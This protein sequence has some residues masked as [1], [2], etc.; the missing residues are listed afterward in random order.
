MEGRKAAS[1]RSEIKNHSFYG[2]SAEALIQTH[3]LVVL[4]LLF[5]FSF[6]A[7]HGSGKRLHVCQRKLFISLLVK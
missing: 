2:D 3:V 4:L 6:A 5:G 7:L 1:R